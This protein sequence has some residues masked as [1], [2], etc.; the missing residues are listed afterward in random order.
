MQ[1]II[2]HASPNEWLLLASL[3]NTRYSHI[4]HALLFSASGIRQIDIRLSIFFCLPIKVIVTTKHKRRLLQQSAT[5]MAPTQVLPR[6]LCSLVGLAGSAGGVD[7]SFISLRK[8][9]VCPDQG[10]ALPCKNRPPEKTNGR[11]PVPGIKRPCC[12]PV[13][14]RSNHLFFPSPQSAC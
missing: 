11:E 9:S 8:H 13:I 12:L 10:E 3:H 2:H 1:R 6:Q 14:K 5:G 4:L 7:L